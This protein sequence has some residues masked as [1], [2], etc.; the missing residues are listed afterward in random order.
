MKST[1]LDVQGNRLC[2][3]S[4]DCSML[5]LT[6]TARVLT[7]Q[8]VCKNKTLAG[9][10][11]Q[12]QNVHSQLY[13]I[14]LQ[15]LAL[16]LLCTCMRSC[17]AVHTVNWLRN[18]TSLGKTPLGTM[19]GHGRLNRRGL[20]MSELACHTVQQCHS[21]MGMCVMLDVKMMLRINM[22]DYCVCANL[23]ATRIYCC[24]GKVLSL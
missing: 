23:R 16:L 1:T 18:T 24:Q 9:Q 17:R 2:S 19:S 6:H 3:H 20:I 8:A 12:Q 4:R 5:L 22:H 13:P 7:H 21:V 14:G 11:Q 10:Q 15:V